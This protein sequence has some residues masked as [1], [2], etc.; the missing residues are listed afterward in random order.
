[1]NGPVATHSRKLPHRLW[2]AVGVASALVAVA[3]MLSPM[4]AMGTGHVKASK[5]HAKDPRIKVNDGN[6]E[7]SAVPD[8]AQDPL[9][10][11]L[12]NGTVA[13]PSEWPASVVARTCTATLMGPQVLL[14]AAH[15]VG[16]GATV[17]VHNKG[18]ADFTGICTRHDKWSLQNLSPDVALCLMTPMARTGLF[19]ESV[20]WD[21]AHVVAAKRLTLGGYG[22]TDLDAQK[23]EDPPIFRIGPAVVAT[24][25][26]ISAK[27]PQWLITQP[28]KTGSLSF[29][30]PGDSGGAAYRVPPAG[31]RG[32]VGVISAVNDDKEAADYKASYIAALASSEIRSF[33][34]TWL[35]GTAA[36]TEDHKAAR[37]CGVD[38]F[39][40]PCRPAPP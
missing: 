15:C 26:G 40:L 13:T 7:V 30:C 9:G 12:G 8:L 39:E 10:P 6:L 21:V 36:R 23:E 24:A 35:A 27:W 18:L 1:M 37:I 3:T 14:T 17:T 16:N 32:V 5:A 28:A 33:I 34:Q 22:C 4:R 29:A 25:P 2:Y 20:Q 31:V 38:L 11:K 19:F